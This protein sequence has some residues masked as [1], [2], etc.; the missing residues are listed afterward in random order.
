MWQA[1]EWTF[2]RVLP[3]GII[4]NKLS[5]CLLLSR[6]FL[7]L[8]SRGNLCQRLG[9]FPAL[10]LGLSLH[11]LF[12][13]SL[14]PS[15]SVPIKGW[16]GPWMQNNRSRSMGTPRRPKHKPGNQKMAVP[17]V[18]YPGRCGRKS[19]KKKIYVKNHNKR[20]AVFL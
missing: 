9:A 2:S 6:G 11:N 14:P 13:Y 3:D 16:L 20:G 15:Y 18:P 12:Q 8:Y 10:S 4:Q 1:N 5:H 7:P 19:K 17:S